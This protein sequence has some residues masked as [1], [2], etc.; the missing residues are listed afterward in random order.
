[1]AETLAL[2]KS[3]IFL[4]AL[5]A[6][7]QILFTEGRPI[8]SVNK[9][10]V[11]HKE[12]TKQGSDNTINSRQS[13]NTRG[14]QPRASSHIPNTAFG[15]SAASKDDFR[16]TSPGYSPGVGHP[17]EIV[18]SSRLEHSVAE[19][20]DIIKPDG[21]KR[22]VGKTTNLH[23]SKSGKIKGSE[24][25]PFSHIPKSVAGKDE[26]MSSPI[27][28]STSSAAYD[29]RPTDPGNSPYVGH[30]LSQEDSDGET[31]P[32]AP[33]RGKDYG[34]TPGR[35]NRIGQDV[36][37]HRSNSAN[38]KGSQAT[39]SSHIPVNAHHHQT[40]VPLTPTAFHSSAASSTDDFRPTS[41]GF[42]PGVGHP[43][44]V[45]TSFNVETSVT[46]FKD[47]YRPTQPGHSPGVG[48]AYQ[49]NNAE[50]NP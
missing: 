25:I 3:A 43:K 34:F 26:E 18:T 38:I 31:D 30:P 50:P 37:F 42:S 16:P 6:C 11:V 14:S 47:D 19:F 1:M 10:E 35:S 27:G 9:Q 5:I 41:P 29:F 24:T 2:S 45:I 20:K 22:E 32:P 33:G 28:F 46:E 40:A 39:S 4:L 44:A 48:H 15:D 13:K 49:K 7:L 8:K 36:I 21:L 17:K 12:M 23:Q